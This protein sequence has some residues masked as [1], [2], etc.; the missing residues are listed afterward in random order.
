[1]LSR[2]GKVTYF[3]GAQ[4][5][6]C[7]TNDCFSGLGVYTWA[8]GDVY[9]GSFIDGKMTG[10]GTLVADSDGVRFTG[11]WKENQKSGYLKFTYSQT[12]TPAHT[13]I[14][15]SAHTHRI[16]AHDRRLGRLEFSDGAT[17]EGEWSVGRVDKYTCRSVQRGRDTHTHIDAHTQR[18][19]QNVLVA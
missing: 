14:H 7:W 5:E 17:Y 15:T 9:R 8:N 3:N 11:Q 4:Y 1:M 18:H 19:T 13:H 12:H 2:I 16:L 10:Q 6:G